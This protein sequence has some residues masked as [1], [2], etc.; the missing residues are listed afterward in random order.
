MALT[1]QGA[2]RLTSEG[3]VSS[4]LLRASE[5]GEATMLSSGFPAHCVPK[6]AKLCAVSRSCPGEDQSGQELGSRACDRDLIHLPNFLAPG[7]DGRHRCPVCIT[8][9]RAIQSA[10]RPGEE[11]S[12]PGGPSSAAVRN[13]RWQPGGATNNALPCLHYRGDITQGGWSSLYC[14]ER[15]SPSAPL[16]PDAEVNSACTVLPTFFHS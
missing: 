11:R 7:L 5:L 16:Y 13:G 14:L 4:G 9:T 15:V 6:T 10:S 12:S 1:A 8:I 2:Y 3:S